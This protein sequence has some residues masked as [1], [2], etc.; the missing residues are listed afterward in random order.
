MTTRT[1]RLASGILDSLSA[2]ETVA[3]RSNV[4]GPI[5]A[6]VYVY[7]LY[8]L[9]LWRIGSESRAYCARSGLGSRSL[10]VSVL[11]RASALPTGIPCPNIQVVLNR[12]YTQSCTFL[13]QQLCIV[14]M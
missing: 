7:I 5:A 9:V 3:R 11:S 10:S 1:V 12:N 2:S 13:F 14:Y 8:A 4:R 6:A